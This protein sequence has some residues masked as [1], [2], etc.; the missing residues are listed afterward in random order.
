MRT[1]NELELRGKR[2]L[3]RVDFNVPQDRNSGAITDDTRILAALPTLHALLEAGAASLILMS[4]LGR[5]K[6]APD[7]R[8]TLRG[9][10]ER[11][12]EL[13]GRPVVLAPEC[14]GPSAAAAAA[15]L[16]AG[17]VLLLENTR[18][19]PGEEAKDTGKRG[20]LAAQL[21]RLA[22][23]FVNDAFGAAHRA[24]ASTTD[25]AHLLPSA[26][27]LL[28][29]KELAVLGSALNRPARPFVAIL[30][31]SKVSDKIA[32]IENLLPRVDAL[33]VGGGMAFT[34]LKALGYEVGKS[35]LE[36]GH[37]QSSRA[38]LKEAARKGWRILLPSDVVVADR[39]EAPTL[40]KTVPVGELPPDL[41]GLDIGPETRKAFAAELGRAR[42]AVWNGPMGVFEQPVF[43]GG[44]RA[45]GQALRELAWRGGAGIVGGGDSAA[46]MEQMD[47]GDEAIH[48][49]TGGGA[50]L[51]FL[52]GKLLPGV[53][54][55]G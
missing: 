21:A 23:C 48:I 5:P 37:L 17:G 11:L 43:A 50:S 8:W 31:G 29:S 42:L 3:V 12:A 38:T 46:A 25:V 4:H 14:A 24:H 52:E 26:A 34:F 35:L 1:L 20:E 28:M 32:V 41:L 47:L 27:G 45:I 2:V 51:E 22:D 39:I 40:V 19:H 54:A 44:T 36:E 16:P 9:V 10:A 18:F 55:L 13:L 30:G 53:A 49:S 15:A 33:L 6:G 7:P